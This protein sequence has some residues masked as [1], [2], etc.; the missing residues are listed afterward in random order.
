VGEG[1]AG[2]E[3]S[4]LGTGPLQP[5]G[6]VQQDVEGHA[7]NFPQGKQVGGLRQGL[8]Q[9]PAGHRLPGDPQAL[10]QLFL[11]Q[12]PLFPQSLY[13]LSC[14]HKGTSFFLSPV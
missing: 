8:V 3:G 12:P 4:S 14:G 6:W 10:G 9:L 5:S 1:S 11:G 13:L 7:Q 2:A